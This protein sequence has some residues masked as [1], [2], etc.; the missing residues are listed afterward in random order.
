M[1]PVVQ[2]GSVAIFIAML[3]A[4]AALVKPY[5]FVKSRKH[6]LLLAGICFVAFVGT[7]VA[8]NSMRLPA[9]IPERPSTISEDDWQAQIAL[10]EEAQLDAPTCV[11]NDAALK[12]AR[13]RI[14][15][16][17][18]EQ[19]KREAEIAAAAARD[20]AQREREAAAL[21]EQEKAR[22]EAASAFQ[23]DLWIETTK[24]AVRRGLRDPSSAVFRNV[25]IY[26][27]LPNRNTPVVCGEVNSKNGFGGM[28]GYQGFIGSGSGESFPVFLEEQMA[29]GEYEKSAQQLCMNL[30][31]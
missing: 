30:P 1:L 24:D 11:G 28:T 5:W 2:L 19:A 31:R 29:D 17:K 18:A 6:A 15:A 16:R 9:A 10:C 23:D 12:T 4:L 22:Q 14:A 20:A 8:A 3:M 26:R 21:A 13:E 27:P 25:K 7:G